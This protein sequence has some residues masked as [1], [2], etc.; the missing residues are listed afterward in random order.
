[1]GGGFLFGADW[2]CYWPE[3]LDSSFRWNDSAMALSYVSP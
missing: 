1:M 2:I 3:S